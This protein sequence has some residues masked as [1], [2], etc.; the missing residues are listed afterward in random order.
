MR[1]LKRYTMPKPPM[2]AGR[3]NVRA[4]SMPAVAFCPE[5]PSSTKKVA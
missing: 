3:M 5:E 1:Y 2:T 4:L